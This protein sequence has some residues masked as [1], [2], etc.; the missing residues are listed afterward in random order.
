MTQ[1]SEPIMGYDLLGPR[2]LAIELCARLIHATVEA[3]NDAHNELTLTW[4]Q[5][6][7]SLM[8]GIR[9]VLE[10]PYET[11]EE[12]HNAW[13][14]YRRSEGWVYGPIKDPDLKTHPCMVPYMALPP[15]QKS[16]DMVFH[17]I[18]RTF[19]GIGGEDGEPD[20]SEGE[21]DEGT[22]AEEHPDAPERS[23]QEERASGWGGDDGTGA[24]ED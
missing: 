20:Q 6:Q 10:N 18:V 7:E 19:F 24:E 2:E 17:A 13:M 16:K 9:R 3:M 5:S 14:T 23:E 22:G 15:F 11:A 12:N 1:T 4:E 8:D 21:A